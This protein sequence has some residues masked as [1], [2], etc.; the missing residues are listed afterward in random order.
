VRRVAVFKRQVRNHNNVRKGEKVSK[1]ERGEGAR[2]SKKR[3]GDC[4][5]IRGR[6]Y[7]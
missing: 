3:S 5:R 7:I 6:V 1:G 4:T 2:G